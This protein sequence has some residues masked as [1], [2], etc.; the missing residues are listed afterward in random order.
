MRSEKAN[1]QI[2]TIPNILSF[3]RLCLIPVIVW[4]YAWEESYLAAGA[5]LVL[6]G[7]TDVVDGYI[8]RHFGLVSDLGKILDPV[9]DKLTQGAVLLCLMMRFWLMCIPVFMMLTKEIIVGMTGI[10]VI[11]KTGRVYSAEWHGKVATLMLY[12]MMTLHLFWIGI[13]TVVSAASILLCALMIAV[14]FVE[15]GLKNYKLI[16][17][18]CG[19]DVHEAEA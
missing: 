10:I 4:L 14:S 11:R 17:N 7:L 1:A 19:D 3:F 12:A 18:A 13:P 5:V 2:F 9:A 16:N 6:S 8:A 15:Y